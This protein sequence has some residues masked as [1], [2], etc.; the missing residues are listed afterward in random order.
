MP[1][2]SLPIDMP[3]QRYA[4]M[5]RRYLRYAAAWRCVMPRMLLFTPLSY[6]AAFAAAA[7]T[8][9]P[10][11]TPLLII[12]FRCF[13]DTDAIASLFACCLRYCRHYFTLFSSSFSG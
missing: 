2:C 1:L 10:L 6:Y 8:C 7:A 3:L 5:L 11:F 4:T 13:A 12:I 9:C